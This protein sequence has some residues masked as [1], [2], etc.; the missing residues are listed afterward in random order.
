MLSRIIQNIAYACKGDKRY[1]YYNE[2]QRN[3]FISRDQLIDIQ[4]CSI[5][6]IIKHAYTSSAYY[7]NMFDGI[8]IRPEEIRN[9]DDLRALPLLSKTMIKENI[10]L[11][12]TNDEFSKKLFSVTSGGSTGNQSLILKS[13]YFEQ[14]SRAASLRNN[15][16]ANWDPED[17]SVWIWGSPY[18]H[19]QLKGS[20]KAKIGLII[21]NRLLLNAYDYAKA[22][23]PVWVKKIR[24]FKPK[25]VYGYSSI[26]AE[27]AKYLLNNDIRLVSIKSVISTTEALTERRLIQDAFGCKV[28]DQYGCREIPSI[29]IEID[30]GIMRV[31]DDTVVLNV[32][33]NGEFVVT[34][35][36]SY[37]FPLINY[38]VGDFGS[39]YCELTSE[40]DYPFSCVKLKIGRTTD[41]F[42]NI[43]QRKVSSSALSTYISTFNIKIIEQQIVQKDYEDFV[44]NYVPGIDFNFEFYREVIMNSLHEYFG[45]NVSMQYN[46]VKKI[47][48][49]KSG[50]KLMFKRI[51]NLE[52]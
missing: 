35:L 15:L 49:E 3:L 31:S 11:L 12:K 51:F 2:L 27:F 40:D 5:Q 45:K 23:F 36:H 30:E 17:R 4:K 50:K 52:E 46:E 13:P 29:A 38:R 19:A 14:M 8:G 41:N 42:I 21:N 24:D 28:H 22:D 32:E 34:A 18:E 25:V 16:L 37:G 20:L 1:Q 44:V 47:P 33:K 39:E 6:K 26:I 7:K 48:I 10:E 9:K 43:R